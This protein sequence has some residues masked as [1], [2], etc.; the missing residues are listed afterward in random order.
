MTP[1]ELQTK[2]H[3]QIPLTQLMQL[4]IDHINDKELITTAPLDVNINDKGTA[5]GGSLSTQTIISAW[6][7]CFLLSQEL[8]LENSSIVIIKNETKFLHPVTK[9]LS[10]HTFFPTKTQIEELQ[11][12][13]EKK[14]SGSIKI[15]SQIIENEKTCVEFEGTFV[16][17]LH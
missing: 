1:Q 14:G 12:K 11:K 15:H 5:F 13:I 3:T 2:L 6:S 10:C 4:C 8:N 9:A 7:V 16:I 17:K